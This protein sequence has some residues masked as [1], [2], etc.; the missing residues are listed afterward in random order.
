MNTKQL[1][2]RIGIFVILILLVLG[3]P[4]ANVGATPAGTTF[5][6]QGQLTQGGNAV[7]GSCD[8]QFGLWDA[9]SGGGQVAGTTTLTLPG[10]TVTKGLFTVQLDFGA[11]A[12]TSEA[13][14]LEIG[15][16]CAGDSTYTTLAPRQ[17]LTPAP[18]ALYAPAAGNATSVTNGVYTTG[19][20]ANPAWLTALAGSKISGSVASAT[21]ATTVTNGV[22]T[23]GSYADPAWLTALAGSKITGAV[24][25]ATNATNFSGTLSGDVNGTQGSTSVTALRGIAIASTTPTNGQVLQYNGSQWA[26]ASILAGS[27]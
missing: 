15:V 11:S 13:R 20:Y 16:K 10:V 21:N 24:A 25:N 5:T 7:T 22:Y 9:L 27:G 14:W 2:S 4:G 19:S 18:Y 3:F 23:T 17:P 6:Y 12:F 26:A 8:F 1:S